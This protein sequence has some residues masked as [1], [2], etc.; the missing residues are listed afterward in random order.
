M[1]DPILKPISALDPAAAL[2]GAEL[3]PVVQG[4]VNKRVT[5]QEVA[6]LAGGVPA[7]GAQ[8]SVTLS[9]PIPLSAWSNQPAALA[10]FHSGSTSAVFSRAA[11]I[12]TAAYTQARLAAV[13]VVPGSAGATLLV[14][15]ATA[16]VAADQYVQSG[17][18][19]DI[20]ISIATGGLANSGWID[21]SPG[22][23]GAGLV[24]AL[25]GQGGDGVADPNVSF[26]V[27]QFR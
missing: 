13:V 12:D 1:A 10:H 2:T 5:A 16:L 27:L 23:K 17:V 4:G 26:V 20:A 21:L 14:R 7:G 9:A 8:L 19:N 22:A 6:N 3:L 11:L 18:A 15:H 25:M 24:F